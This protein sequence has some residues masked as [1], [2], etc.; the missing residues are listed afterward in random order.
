MMTAINPVRV[1]HMNLVLEDFDASVA[2]F[3][4][5]YGADFLADIPQKEWRACL[6]EMG[7][8]IFELFVPHDFLLNHRH[9]PH[10]V[11]IEYQADMDVVRE[12]VA[13]RGIRIVRDIGIALHT[14]PADCFGVAFEFYGG[15]FHDRE[16]PTIGGRMKSATYWRDKHPLGLTGLKGYD[17]AVADLDAA[18]HFMEGFLGGARA[19]E[20]DRP[21]IGARAVGLQVADAILEVV[22]PTGDG[23]LRDHLHSHGQG[24]RST[25]FGVRDV[26]QARRYFLD[27]GVPV[28]PGFAPG[29]FAVPASVNRGVLFEFAQ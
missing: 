25:L 7:R 8:V 24:I 6:V 5:F 19:Y 26:D 10:F 21:E 1:N 29:S 12:S 28:E 27:R 14:H 22:A 11:G 2:H 16:W 18:V 20:E 3:R 15:Y 17:V 23:S 9:G 13:Q 4:D